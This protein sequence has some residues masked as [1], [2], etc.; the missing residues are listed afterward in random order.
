MAPL[1]AK[2]TFVEFIK[3]RQ[4]LVS[5]ELVGLFF[6]VYSGRTFSKFKVSDFMVGKKFGEFVLTKRSFSPKKSRKSR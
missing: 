4:S 6:Q 2:S 5:P 3:S 1:L